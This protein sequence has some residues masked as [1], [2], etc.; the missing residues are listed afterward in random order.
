[1]LT[2]D[3]TR[4]SQSHSLKPLVPCDGPRFAC[5]LSRSLK[6]GMPV[7]PYTNDW[8]D[9]RA[10]DWLNPNASEV[11]KLATLLEVSQALLAA[12]ELKTGL[13]E[14]LKILGEHHG[15]IRSTVV[16]L[17][18]QT[19]EVVEAASAGVINGQTQIGAGIAGNVIKTGKPV[20]VPQVN[21]EARFVRHTGMRPEPP[22][23][24]FTYICVPIALEGQ[25]VGALAID[26]IYKAAR[27]Y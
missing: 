25:S 4:R 13:S 9:P 5:P 12:R 19:G 20:I 27:D 3:T 14:V 6:Q 22:S 11:R 15:A 23:Q 7:A 17:N 8:L 21:H 2:A 24:Q 1:M 18:Q 16:L 10:N 26:L